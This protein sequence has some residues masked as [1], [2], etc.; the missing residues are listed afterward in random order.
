MHPSVY[1]LP[2]LNDSVARSNVGNDYFG[3]DVVDAE[4]PIRSDECLDLRAKE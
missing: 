1:K 2:Y 3:V 4:R